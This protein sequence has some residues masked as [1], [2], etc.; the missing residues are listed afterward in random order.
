M[1][2]SVLESQGRL[3]RRGLEGLGERVG[4]GLDNYFEAEG[5]RLLREQE[6]YEAIGGVVAEQ[7]AWL[8]SSADAEFDEFRDLRPRQQK[9]RIRQAI[10]AAAVRP[11]DP[12]APFRALLGEA[13]YEGRDHF[14]VGLLPEPYETHAGGLLDEAADPEVAATLAAFALPG[15]GWVAGVGFGTALVLKDLFSDDGRHIPKLIEEAFDDLRNGFDTEP[16][17]GDRRNRSR[18]RLR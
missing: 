11:N 12:S 17:S 16:W 2:R 14:L 15:P 8:A 4:S 7:G 6:G 1:T 13:T 5:E 18:N 10:L 9:E 3:A